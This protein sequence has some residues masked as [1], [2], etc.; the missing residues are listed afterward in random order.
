MAI[1]R[2]RHVEIV[3]DDQQVFMAAQRVGDFLGGGADVDEQRAAVRNLRRGRYTNRL[4]LLGGDETARLIGEVLDA[5]GDDG[6]AMN[7]VSERWSQRSLRS[8]RMVCADTSKRLA[9]S[10]TITRPKARA[11]LRISV[12]RWDSPATRHP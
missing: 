12:W 7:A 8:L 2:H 3:G 5:G 1:E 9:R 4:L 11:I 10:S 6:A